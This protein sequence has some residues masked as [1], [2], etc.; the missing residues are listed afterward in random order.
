MPRLLYLAEPRLCTE[1]GFRSLESLLKRSEEDVTLRPNVIIVNGNLSAGPFVTDT[2]EEV[3]RKEAETFASIKEDLK[4]YREQARTTISD[5][6]NYGLSLYNLCK[7]IVD[8]RGSCAL[9]GV[10]RS[11]LLEIAKIYIKG[12][13]ESNRRMR[14]TYERLQNILEK[15]GRPFFVLHGNLDNLSYELPSGKPSSVAGVF[16]STVLLHNPETSPNFDSPVGSVVGSGGAYDN[17]TPVETP[18][19]FV[20]HIGERVYREVKA[21]VENIGTLWSEPGRIFGRAKADIVVSYMPPLE[22]LDYGSA[23]SIGLTRYLDSACR[24]GNAPK[25]C[26]CAQG[27]LDKRNIGISRFDRGV[28]VLNPG[29]FGVPNT[30]SMGTFAVIDFSEKGDYPRRAMIYSFDQSD[31]SVKKRTEFRLTSSGPVIKNFD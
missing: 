14:T 9:F 5:D 23:P 7:Q 10:N 15:S 6:T 1:I 24:E 17:L 22:H 13:E 30:E 31:S 18:D 21:G 4:A 27:A 19:E 8:S 20:S 25:L 29:S 11:T 16:G 2:K 3:A 12:V 26:L 28:Y